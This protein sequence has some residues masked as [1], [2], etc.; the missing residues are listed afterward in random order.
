MSFVFIVNYKLPCIA[1]KILAQ[2]GEVLLFPGGNIEYEAIKGHPDIYLI[3]TEEKLLVAGNTPVTFIEKLKLAGIDFI[4]L[5]LTVGSLYPETT[6]MN[7]W[8]MPEF[9]LCGTANE[10][11][12][13]EL[14]PGKKILAAKQSYVRCTTFVLAERWFTSDK[15]I[16]RK[17]KEKGF[18]ATYIFPENIKLDPFPH[19]FAGG[20]LGS[21]EDK[22]F[23]CGDIACA[24]EFEMIYDHAIS[25]KYEWVNLLPGQVA[26]DFGGIFCLSV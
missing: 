12:W 13:R 6:V 17:L 19:G 18:L 1:T 5:P 8:H 4:K 16:L 24:P 22:V 9:I 20:C 7:S 23:F 14:F 25:E 15:G 21:A 10:I 3:Q 11:I 26:T 2:Y